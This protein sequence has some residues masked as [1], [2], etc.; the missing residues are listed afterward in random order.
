MQENCG[1]L[2]TSAQKDLLSQNGKAWGF[3]GPT[4]QKNQIPEKLKR[5]IEKARA[6]GIPVIHSP[7]GFPFAEMTD[8]KPL[9]QIQSVIVE[10]KLLEKD[11]AGAEFI[12][13]ATPANG[14]TVLPLRQGFSSY[15][16]QSIQK[17]LKDAGIDTL[18]IAGMLAEGCVESHSRDAV[19]NG[20]RPIV[21]SD[22][23]GSTSE[24]LL[25]ASLS[26][27]AL[28]SAECISTED[29]LKRW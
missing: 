20:V 5:L 26:T 6:A 9:S 19:E 17:H 7:V 24:D 29:V 16:A 23:I 10:H 18:Y 15:W 1:L 22:A 4:V 3:T 21:I 13:E 2:I 14:D 11:S 8:F 12:P 25:K 28:H 27:L